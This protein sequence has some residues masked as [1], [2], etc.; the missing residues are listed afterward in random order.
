[1][2]S[3]AAI[4]VLTTLVIFLANVVYKT[5]FTAGENFSR[6]SELERWRGT[7]REDMREISDILTQVTNELHKLSTLIEERT[8]RR[9]WTTRQQGGE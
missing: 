8:D 6:I 3:W 9:N 7:I 1:M 2:W 4:G 5:A